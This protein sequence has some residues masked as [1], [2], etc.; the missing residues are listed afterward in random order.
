MTPLPPSPFVDPTYFD[1]PSLVE[2]MLSELNQTVGIAVREIQAQRATQS[3]FD[4][5]VEILRG[6]APAFLADPSPEYLAVV[7]R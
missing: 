5:I 3:D 2:F 6:P 4:A 1:P 7:R